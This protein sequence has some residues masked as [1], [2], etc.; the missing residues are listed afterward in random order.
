MPQEL[1][2]RPA[3]LCT[4]DWYIV[5]RRFDLDVVECTRCHTR[6]TAPATA[7]DDDGPPRFDFRGIDAWKTNPDRP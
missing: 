3:V 2:N 6:E 5:A 7:P 4:H 1:R